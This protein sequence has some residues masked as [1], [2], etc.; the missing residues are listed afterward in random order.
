MPDVV[1]A[2]NQKKM[3]LLAYGKKLKED[4]ERDR[5]EIDRQLEDINDALSIV[6]D[7]VKDIL[8]KTCGGTGTVR[9]MDAAGQMDDEDCPNCKGTGIKIP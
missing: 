1:G 3:R 5:A 6:N 4:Y 9:K 7:A 8:C 2:L